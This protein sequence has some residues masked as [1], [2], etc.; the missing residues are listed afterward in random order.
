MKALLRRCPATLLQLAG[1][2]AVP[3]TI[4]IEDSNINLPEQRADHVFIIPSQQDATAERAIYCE[5]QLTPDSRTL[6]TWF[7]KC[8]GLTRQLGMQVVLLAVYL[9]RGDR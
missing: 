2:Q 6:S 5:Y 4:R 1:M 8:G 3:E 9:Q 7:S